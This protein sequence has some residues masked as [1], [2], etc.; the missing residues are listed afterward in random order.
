MFMLRSLSVDK[1][2]ADNFITLMFYYLNHNLLQAMA[3]LMELCF[4]YFIESTPAKL[5][6]TYQTYWQTLVFYG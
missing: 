3:G 5:K 2:K 4:H 1:T 6:S